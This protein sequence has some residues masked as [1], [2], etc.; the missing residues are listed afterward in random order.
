VD[1]Q[2]LDLAPGETVLASTSASFRGA[3]AGSVR[4]S[5]A[6]GSSR[7]RHD[8]FLAWREQASAI[9]FPTANAEMRL[10]LTD[11]RLI[12]C[13]TS[14]W[15]NRPNGVAGSLPLADIAEVAIVRQ[16]WLTTI[17]IAIKHRGIVELEALRGRPLRRVARLIQSRT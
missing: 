3:A 15:L 9:G 6:L 7:F 8:R 10:V 12:V 14:F 11:Q 13:R 5:S 2:L 4:V 1:I 17:A 16:G